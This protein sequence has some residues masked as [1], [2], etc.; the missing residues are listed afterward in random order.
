MSGK[1]SKVNEDEVPKAF[2]KNNQR[3]KSKKK[4]KKS[5]IF[6]RILVALL[7]IIAIV[8]GVAYAFIAG[9]IGKTNRIDLKEEE[10]SISE[11]E[12][13]KG[14]RN[15]A[16][17]GIDSRADD[18]GM[19]NR[20]DSIIIAS[21]NNNT[22]DIKLVSVYRD[23]YVQIEGHGLDKITHA[24]S[25]GGPQLAIKTLNTNLDLNIK[26]FFTVNFD[27]VAEAVDLLGG[28]T[29]EIKQEELNVNQGQ[30]LNRYI[31]AVAKSTGREAS[32]I[33][34]PGV[35][36]LD[37]VQAVAYSRNR[38]ISGGDYARSEKMRNVMEAMLK[39]LK[40]KSVTEINSFIDKM[41]PH[42]YTNITTGDVISLVPNIAKYNVKESVGWPYNT[43]GITLAAWYGVP[44]TLESNVEKL[45]KEVFED[46]EYVVSDTVKSISQSIVN[47]TGY[48]E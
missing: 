18:Y 6:I 8:L 4:T 42:V 37:G 47:K 19:G 30:S 23:T 48:S 35:Y 15:I 46:A 28:V 11:N 44:V 24:Y 39:K 1:H 29:M 16:I 13:L 25:F 27:A 14:Y 34:K 21:I 5:K 12:T 36:N 26:E 40:A 3:Q 7:L 9:K 17:F 33:E 2:Q 43:K 31:T 38:F 20:S 32:Y 41:L 45:H 22:G 10:L